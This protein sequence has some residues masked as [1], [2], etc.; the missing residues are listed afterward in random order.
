MGSEIKLL[1]Q[2][3]NV[4]SFNVETLLTRF[5]FQTNVWWATCVSNFVHVL[6][7]QH[8]PQTNVFGEQNAHQ[9]FVL[10]F[11]QQHAPQTDVH[12]FTVGSCKLAP[13]PMVPDDDPIDHR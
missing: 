6:N 2:T 1:T 9:T 7:E 11:N 4:Y 8:A 5:G 12:V 10:D 13:I 3:I